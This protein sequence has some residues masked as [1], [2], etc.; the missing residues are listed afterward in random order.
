[1]VH[2]VNVSVGDG[3]VKISEVRKSCIIFCGVL[4]ATQSRI[5]H[6]IIDGNWSLCGSSIPLSSFVTLH[7][8]SSTPLLG[9]LASARHNLTHIREAIGGMIDV[10]VSVG[11]VADD[12]CFSALTTPVDVTTVKGEDEVGIDVVSDDNSLKCVGLKKKKVM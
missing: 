1:M 2:D 6:V 3:V 5:C 10:V 4:L 12:R 11:V 9:N 7:P 8:P